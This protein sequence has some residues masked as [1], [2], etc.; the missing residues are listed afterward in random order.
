MF[1]EKYTDHFFA[2]KV[3]SYYICCILHIVDHR[4]SLIGKHVPCTIYNMYAITNGRGSVQGTISALRHDLH[5]EKV[6]ELG[7]K[8]AI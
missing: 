5:Y 7:I 8:F 4:K 3:N 2:F 1:G 6:G